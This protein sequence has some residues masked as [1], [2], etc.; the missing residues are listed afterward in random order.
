M[1]GV[2][3]VTYSSAPWYFGPPT[4]I[5]VEG[6]VLSTRSLAE[7]RGSTF[8]TQ[9]SLRH[10]KRCSPSHERAKGPKAVKF[11]HD[12]PS[13][14]YVVFRIPVPPGS[15]TENDRDVE[16]VTYVAGP[17]TFGVPT[18]REVAGPGVTLIVH[19]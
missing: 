9:S 7:T 5:D 1:I 12:P 10:S 6:G 8:P 3:D 2:V 13:T 4:T 14:R 15:T 11:V 17:V 16:D 19:V 18:T